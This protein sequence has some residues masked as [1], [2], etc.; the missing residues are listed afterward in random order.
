MRGEAEDV[1]GIRILDGHKL[2]I[3]LERPFGP[4]LGLLT[5]TAAYAV[6]EEE[7]E[8]LGADFSANPVGTGPFFLSEWLPN[9]ELRLEKNSGYFGQK[10]KAGGM[11][12]RVIPEELTTVTEFELGNLDVITIPSSVYSK[13]R[14]DPKWKGRISSV[15]GLN[16][17]YLGMNCSRAPFDD[18]TLRRALNHAIDRRKIL[19]TLYEGRGRPAAGPVPDVLRQ[20]AP[21]D[22]YV[23][24]M[25]KAKRMIK[26]S[27]YKGEALNLYITAQEETAD[28][29]EVIQSYLKEAGLDVRIRQLEWSAYKEAINEGEPELFWLSWWADYPDPEN[30]LYPLFHSSNMGPA[31]NRVRYSNPHVDSLIEAG[32]HAPSPKERNRLYEEAERLIVE[33]APWV[34]FWH[35][36]DFALSRPGV[37][38]YHMYPIYSMEKGT[39][40]EL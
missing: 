33:D 21:P 27:R 14:K 2:E 35:R 22:E 13:Y 17:Y 40:V 25:E 7:V 36:T 10:A 31:G 32:R 4:F 26:E 20:W 15:E 9:R 34:F 8:R 38:G 6:P 24:D 16:T 12:Y 5:M 19:R 29:A 30:F 1:G 39:E 28:M 23:F 37:K 18:R 11:V 3:E